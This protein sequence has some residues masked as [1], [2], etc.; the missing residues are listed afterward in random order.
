ME[1]TLSWPKRVNALTKCHCKMLP[2]RIK[3]LWCLSGNPMLE[4]CFQ[5]AHG[6]RLQQM[7]QSKLKCYPSWLSSLSLTHD[8]VRDQRWLNKV[9]CQVRC[10]IHVSKGFNNDLAQAH[11]PCLK[12]IQ[13]KHDRRSTVYVSA[14]ASELERFAS[15]KT[16]VIRLSTLCKHYLTNSLTKHGW[17]YTDLVTPESYFIDYSS[18]QGMFDN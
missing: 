6:I 2:F 8:P 1:G 14:N 3:K 5:G 12:Q 15:K 17:C 16:C 13:K 4:D 18:Y 10:P 9:N 7:E 11:F